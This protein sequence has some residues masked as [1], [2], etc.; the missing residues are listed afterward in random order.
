M[1]VN[2]DLFK[3]I[4]NKLNADI[5]VAQLLDTY[6]HKTEFILMFEKYDLKELSVFWKNNDFD[7]N[8]G[9]LILGDKIIN[10]F[11]FTVWAVKKDKNNH[12]NC[13]DKENCT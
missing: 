12:S 1:D 2:N 10:I 4:W 5:T 13:C 9:D 8:I 6:I 3:Q 11:T 7:K